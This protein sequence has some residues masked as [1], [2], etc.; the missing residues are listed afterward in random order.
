M[1]TL[2]VD[3]SCWSPAPALTPSQQVNMTSVLVDI[4]CQRHLW[5]WH[6]RERNKVSLHLH[7]VW[8]QRDMR[9]DKWEAKLT[10]WWV[11]MD[12]LRLSWS[13]QTSGLLWQPQEHI[14]Q[15]TLL[16]WTAAH[17]FTY[18]PTHLWLQPWEYS[19][20]SIWDVDN[21]KKEHFKRLGNRSEI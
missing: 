3:W 15:N 7:F 9:Q 6:G 13:L 1:E 5:S 8:S 16:P 21:K 4:W 11:C 19:C 17:L 20:L 2:V 10:F 14:P 12:N 18:H